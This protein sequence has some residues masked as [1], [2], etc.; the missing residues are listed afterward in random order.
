MKIHGP[1][2][3]LKTNISFLWN[4]NDMPCWKYN[5]KWIPK[6]FKDIYFVL[7]LIET[8]IWIKIS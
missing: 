5:K 7:D 2:C 3:L 6:S 8:L 1:Y 4:K